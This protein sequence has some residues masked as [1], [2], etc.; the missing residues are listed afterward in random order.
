MRDAGQ[1]A[2][3]DEWRHPAMN[4]IDTRRETVPLSMVEADKADREVFHRTKLRKAVAV[5]A[6]VAALIG[7]L[8][9]QRI[10]THSSPEE[11]ATQT[12]H[13]AAARACFMLYERKAGKK[14]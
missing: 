11:C 7:F 10:P 5:T 4:S 3:K 13:E 2:G 14:P 9:G 1:K 8:A 6:A 12:S